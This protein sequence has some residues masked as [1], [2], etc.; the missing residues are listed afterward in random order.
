MKKYAMSIAEILIAMTFIS[1]LS[2]VAMNGLR[3]FINRDTDVTKFK[4]AFATISEIVY[5]MKN[6][7]YM[8][9]NAIGFAD[10]NSHTYTDTNKTYGGGSK[11]RRLFASKFNIMEKDK[12]ITLDVS[13][14]LV[15]YKNA[16]NNEVYTTSNKLNCFIENKGFMYC[17]PDTTENG[18]LVSIYLPVYINKI[19]DNDNVSTGITKTIFVQIHKNG[20]L[21]IPPIIQNSSSTKIIDCTNK[22]Y[23]DYNHC[24]ILATM[25]NVSF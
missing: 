15:K 12:K 22:N 25:T 18:T 16:S 17:P 23:N 20:K 8:Y 6:D 9:P 21:D 3:V 19:S 24:K 10:T 4:H 7:T 1:I 13:V 14:P 2:V 5:Q 11:F